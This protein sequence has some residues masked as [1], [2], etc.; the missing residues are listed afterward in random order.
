MALAIRYVSNNMA[1]SN[2]LSLINSEGK[3]REH[4]AAADAHFMKKAKSKAV[5]KAKEKKSKV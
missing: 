3:D 1:K 4:V 5:K 2:D